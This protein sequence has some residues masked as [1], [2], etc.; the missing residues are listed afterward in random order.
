[1]RYDS[2]SGLLYSPMEYEIHPLSFATLGQAPDNWIVSEMARFV[3][4]EFGSGFGLSRQKL[5]STSFTSR[6]QHVG[7][8]FVQSFAE[9]CENNSVYQSTTYRRLP[10]GND[11]LEITGAIYDLLCDPLVG[12]QLNSRNNDRSSFVRDHIASVERKERL[13]FILPGFPFKDQ[14][15]FRV[16]YNANTVD[17]GEISLMLGLHNLTQAIYQ[18][19]PY[20]ADILVLCDGQIYADIFGVSKID[21][22]D[23]FGQLVRHRNFLNIQGTVSFIDMHD[24]FER[25]PGG[26][27]GRPIAFELCDYIEGRLRELVH[28]GEL[29]TEHSVLVRGM[30]WNM[31]TR[32]MFVELDDH[33]CLQIVDLPRA[34][35]SPQVFTAWDN[36]NE[37]AVSAAF[38]YAATNLTMRYLNLIDVVFPRCIRGTVHA[39]QGQFALAASQGLYPWNGI[40]VVDRLDCD[41]SGVRIMEVGKLAESEMK[42]LTE[43]RLDGTENALF[44]LLEK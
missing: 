43:F 39:K 31:N 41:Y 37:R 16:P 25:T 2:L 20:G 14:N 21:V 22:R 13:L 3:R 23:Y 10:R 40:P 9:R 17:L 1:M 11:P 36:M 18:V 33:D 28:L 32:T 19:H 30:K 6:T 8:D 34:D 27:E 4:G 15:R 7:Y 26:Q 35:C 24:L 29:S 42:R 5:M 44:F 12:S 38:R